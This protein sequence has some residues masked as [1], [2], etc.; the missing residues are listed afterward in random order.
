MADI[1]IRFDDTFDD[2]LEELRRIEYLS[3][4]SS[5]ALLAASIGFENQVKAPSRGT[6]DVR[7]AVMLGA[8]GALALFNAI[9]LAS[10]EI[11][12]E[13]PLNHEQLSARAKVFESFV[14]GGL[15]SLQEIRAQGRTLS[16]AIPEL[17]NQK[18]KR[19]R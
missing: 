13:D 15:K 11:E 19:A 6:K 16:V 4:L 7:L 8:P 17:I 9:A 12:D 1:R 3:D 10:G 5:I 14:N 2:V 18:L